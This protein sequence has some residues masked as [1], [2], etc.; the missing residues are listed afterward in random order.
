M[1]CYIVCTLSGNGCNPQIDVRL[2]MSNF[3]LYCE[4]G[5]DTTYGSMFKTEWK[6]GM[7]LECRKCGRKYY[8]SIH[9]DIKDIV[10]KGEKQ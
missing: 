2:D 4:C 8:P 6:E 5:V 9:V 10:E 3:T 7:C 1:R